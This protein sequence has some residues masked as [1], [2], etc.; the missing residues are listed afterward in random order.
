[1]IRYGAGRDVIRWTPKLRDRIAGGIFAILVVFTAVT[2]TWMMRQAYAV[3][4]LT[5]GVGDTVFVAADGKPWF[6]LDEHRRDVPLDQIPEHLRNAFIAIEDHRFFSHPGI[7]P[8]GLARAIA[9]NVASPGMREGG[10]TLTQQLARTLFLSNKRTYGRKAREAI[11]ALMIDAQLSKEQVL[12]LY[13]NRIYLSAG[14][15]GVETMAQHLFGRPAL[16]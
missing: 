9:R 13:L 4:R 2:I 3:F 8:I 1:V 5:R 6:R 10:S 11:L 12:E 14:V 16:R 15:Y 7:D